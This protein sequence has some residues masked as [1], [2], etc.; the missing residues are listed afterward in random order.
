METPSPNH[1]VASGVLRKARASLK[2]LTPNRKPTSF[3]PIA[4]SQE[5]WNLEYSSGRWTY[6]DGI[7][8]VARYSVI[9]GYIFHFKPGGSVLDVGCGE[10]VLHKRLA[11]YGYGRYLGIDCSDEAISRTISRQDAKTH[12]VCA[13]ALSFTPNQAF[14]VI[15]FNECLYYFE[16]PL[17]VLRRHEQYLASDGICVVSMT[18]IEST[19][20]IWKMLD[21][22]TAIEDEIRLWHR[23]DRSWVIKVLRPLTLG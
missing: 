15:V 14:D 6:L 7:N 20:K 9:A 10:G 19:A 17:E 16:N 4:V 12:F 13:D 22:S 1:D 23:S 2:V 5:Q 21:S 11:P 3:R 18:C 8:Q